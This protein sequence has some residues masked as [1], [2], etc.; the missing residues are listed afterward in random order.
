MQSTSPDAELPGRRRLAFE[1]L[2]ASLTVLFQEL[3]LIRWLP[4]RVRVIAYF[5]NLI[6]LS[7]FLGIGVGCLRSRG[8][9]LRWLWP[10]SLVALVGV[11]LLLSRVAFTQESTS[12]HLWLLY[13]DLG[14]DAPVFPDVRS[15]IIGAF[16]LCA[17]SFVPL[18]Q[19][20]A[21][22]LDA[23]RAQG[24]PLIGYGWDLLGSMLGVIGFAVV[25]FL[26]TFPVA[27]F[28]L[29]AL[30][31]AIFFVRQA[32]ALAV[33]AAA[34]GLVVAMVGLSESAEQ[35]SP[36]YA[37]STARKTSVDVSVTVNGSLHQKILDV[38]PLVPTSGTL[39]NA[40]LGYHLPYELLHRKPGRVLVLGAGTGNDVAVA[41]AE[42]ADRVDAVEI[43]PVILELGR[44]LHPDH[45][46]DSP[47]VHTFNTDARSF[48]SNTREKYDLIVFGTLDSLTRLSALSSVRLD[49]FVYT[50]ESL[51]SARAALAPDGGVVLYFLI[52]TEHLHHRLLEMMDAAFE[53]PP[54]VRRDFRGV[55]NATYMAGPAFALPPSEAAEARAAIASLPQLE[56]ATDDWPYLYLHSRGLSPFY[57]TLIAALGALSMAA[58]V[59]ASRE[60]RGA[61]RTFRGTDPEMF[62][63]G[64]GFLLL[65]TA[66]VT[67]MTLVWGVTWLTSAVV[68][69]SILLMALLGTLLQR[70]RPLPWPVSAL[71]IAAALLAGYAVPTD[72]LAA[73]SIL[74]RLALSLVF[75]GAPIFFA[76]TL[77][78][79]AFQERAQADLAFGWNLLGAVAGGLLEFLSMLVGIKALHLLALAAYLGVA[80]LRSR[81]QTGASARS[82]PTPTS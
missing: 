51:R 50:L 52:G 81:V 14:K 48:L 49:N 69:A 7:A 82:A 36:Y 39:E 2:L 77:F 40:R 27:W 13:Y 23:F 72:A 59:L 68:F 44:R 24:R 20:V 64:A 28:A 55:F 45:P 74:A 16:V 9:D 17:V 56:L 46:Y 76:A 29:V 66:S 70:R 1:L 38:G 79:S 21:T 43:D 4:A 71:F 42:G 8:R 25:C 31:G 61:L 47:R 22:R 5:P 63:L 33:Y 3:T 73:G 35:Y 19:L 18:G 75:V 60:L 58:V 11:A 57:L 12:E 53:A 78:A 6:L 26:R 37:L 30:L 62:L 80:L 65:E 54:R 34:M 41:L 15:P 32:R 67:E 10:A